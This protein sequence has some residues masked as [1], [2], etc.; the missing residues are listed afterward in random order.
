MCLS[1]DH[2]LEVMKKYD[3]HTNVLSLV[4]LHI[5]SLSQKG[6]FSLYYEDIAFYL[7]RWCFIGPQNQRFWSKKGCIFHPKYAKTG[8]FSNM[9]TSFGGWGAGGAKSNIL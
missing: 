9:G 4:Q 8:C 5:F 2:N 1:F 7:K 6:F 3:I